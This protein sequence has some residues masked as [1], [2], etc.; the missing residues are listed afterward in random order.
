MGHK[1][2]KVINSVIAELIRNY[3]DLTM[4]IPLKS[5]QELI[6]EYRNIYIPSIINKV[7]INFNVN[8]FS[9]S[10]FDVET[11]KDDVLKILGT[12]KRKQPIIDN[13]TQCLWYASDLDTKIIDL[14]VQSIQERI[15]YK[16]KEHI[17]PGLFID[18]KAQCSTLSILLI[19]RY[20]YISD[21]MC[22]IY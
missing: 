14:F 11:I 16:L 3:L 1:L 5:E 15:N 9:N 12:K 7:P 22:A 2:V 4:M 18:P 10:M 21:H 19:F 20:I 8:E 13:I 17:I 6:Q